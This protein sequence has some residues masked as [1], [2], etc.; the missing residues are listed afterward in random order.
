MSNDLAISPQFRVPDGSAISA[1]PCHLVTVRKPGS[2]TIERFISLDK[3]DMTQSACIQVK[4]FFVSEDEETVITSFRQLLS[5][6]NKEN[7]VETIFPWHSVCRV[8]SLVFK[9]K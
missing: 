7:I 4:G 8:R 5:E 9:A 6:I 2:N 1:R 3:P